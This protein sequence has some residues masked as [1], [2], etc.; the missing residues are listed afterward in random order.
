MAGELLAR[1]LSTSLQVND[2]RPVKDRQGAASFK[3]ASRSFRKLGRSG[4]HKAEPT[5]PCPEALL[6]HDVGVCILQKLA[7]SEDGLRFSS[8]VAC[9]SVCKAWRAALQARWIR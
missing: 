3:K 8:W 2:D 4:K 1:L 5:Q 7:Q 9:A 6:E